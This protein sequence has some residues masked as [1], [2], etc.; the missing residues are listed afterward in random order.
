MD[1]DAPG[2]TGRTEP[3][4]LVR[5]M[6]AVVGR[7]VDAL[8]RENRQLQRRAA[9][10]TFAVAAAFALAA[11]ALAYGLTAESRVAGV[12]HARE[13]VLYDGD[14]LV[15]GRLGITPE[16]GSR[17]VLKDRSDRERI[18]MTLLSDGSPGLSFADAEGRSRMVLAF[19]PD[20]TA[21]LVLA[22]RHGRTR[23]VFGLMPDESST[24]VFADHNGET[25]V[26]LGIDPRGGAGLT[27]VEHG[28]GRRTQPAPQDTSDVE[29]SA[30]GA[31]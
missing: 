12:V 7:R 19:L 20:Q 15:R 22:D 24:L 9:T 14:G 6:E 30:D 3:D 25:R 10:L 21:N 17:L 16:G 31:S 2:T 27:V 29:G 18:R 26:G 5:E 4:P 13:F 11:G 1:Y 8:E 28:N 23:A